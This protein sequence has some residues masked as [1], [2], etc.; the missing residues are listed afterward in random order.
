MD[1]SSFLFGSDDKF[2]KLKNFSPEQQ[3]FFNQFMQQLMGMQGGENGGGVNQGIDILQQYLN[4]ESDIYK[5]FEKPYMQQFE[6]Q[7]VPGLAEKFAGFG[8][9]MGGGLSSSGFGQALSSAGSNLQTNLAQMKSQM[10]RSAIGDIFGQFNTMTGQ[11]L[12]AQPFSYG[13]QQGT[14]GLLPQMAVAA[15]GGVAQGY[16]KGLA[17]GG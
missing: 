15:A 11:G 6:Q 13:H 12:G 9:G 4:P 7:T 16:G 8:G 14:A 17:G 3:Q 5:N 2:K 10:Q 1:L